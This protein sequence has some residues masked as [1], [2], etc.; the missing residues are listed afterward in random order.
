MRL[1]VK[2]LTTNQKMNL[3][4]RTPKQLLISNT[5]AAFTLNLTY[6]K[7]V[8]LKNRTKEKLTK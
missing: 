4:A 6:F 1:S 8:G 7:Y 2:H 3:Y 5:G